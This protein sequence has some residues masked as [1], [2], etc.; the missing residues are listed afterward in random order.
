MKTIITILRMVVG[1]M[2]GSKMN[3]ISQV[4]IPKDEKNI[5][6]F[7]DQAMDYGVDAVQVM[8]N[9]CDW[10]VRDNKLEILD[11]LLTRIL[12]RGY[13]RDSEHT[14]SIP[15]LSARRTGLFPTTI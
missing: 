13:V 2:T 3:I 4:G 15:S 5:Y 7:I 9:L 11:K 1:V 8:G 12:S 10:C 6:E 14:R